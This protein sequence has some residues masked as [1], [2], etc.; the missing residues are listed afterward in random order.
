[1]ERKLL[2]TLTLLNHFMVFASAAVVTGLL[3]YFMN[4][5]PYRG[6]H[7][8]YQEVIAVVTLAVYLVAMIFPLIK[9]YWG[10]FMPL[11]LIFSYLW[12]KSFIFSTQDWNR[13]RCWTAPPGQGLCEKKHTVEAFNFLAFPY[14][15]FLLFC[16]ALAEALI[17]KAHDKRHNVPQDR[18]ET[19]ILR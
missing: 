17:W 5:Y 19:S 3:S 7:I 10:H 11:H 13:G 12:L 16:D 8:V 6:V 18:P 4:E 1:M 15:S 14:F 9:S 2:R